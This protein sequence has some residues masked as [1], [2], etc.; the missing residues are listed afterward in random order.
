MVKGKKTL[1]TVACAERSVFM[2]LTLSLLVSL[3]HSDPGLASKP[4]ISFHT[5][6]FINLA[7]CDG[8]FLASY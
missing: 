5:G 7:D 2:A 6:Q 3:S 4:W 8:T 1:E